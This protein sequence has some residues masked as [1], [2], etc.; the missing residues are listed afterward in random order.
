MV[1]TLRSFNAFLFFLD[2][3]ALSFHFEANSRK[4][5]HID[6]RHP[7]QSKACNQIPSPVWIKKLKTGNDQ[8]YGCDVVAEAV[9]AREE[10]EELAFVDS[11]AGCAFP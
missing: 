1:A 7:Y 5:A 3:D 4:Q 11:A 2:L 6:V 10:I 8:K 9:L